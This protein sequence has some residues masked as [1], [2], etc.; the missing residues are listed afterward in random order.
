MSGLAADTWYDC[1]WYALK[2]ASVGGVAF[3]CGVWDE[4]NSGFDDDTSGLAG[5]G[6]IY[7]GVTNGDWGDGVTDT[8]VRFDDF[9]VYFSDQR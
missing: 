9:E 4:S 1:Y 5:V 6:Y 2:H 3:K 8:N 7:F